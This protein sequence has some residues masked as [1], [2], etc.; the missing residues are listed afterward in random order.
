MRRIGCDRTT[1]AGLND[2]GPSMGG[3]RHGKWE[4]K[5]FIEGAGYRN[6][7]KEAREGR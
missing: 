5:D 7:P 2:D 3:E 4:S 1:D 6:G